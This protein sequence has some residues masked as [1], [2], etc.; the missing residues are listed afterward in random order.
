[1]GRGGREG[2]KEDTKERRKQKERNKWGRREKE[3]EEDTER[4]REKGKKER[5]REKE[6]LWLFASSNPVSG[7]PKQEIQSS[8]KIACHRL[9]SIYVWKSGC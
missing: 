2:K 8:A 5:G 9:R 7:S 3:E 6:A 1:M 4:K